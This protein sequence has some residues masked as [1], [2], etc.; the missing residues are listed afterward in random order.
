[1][2]RYGANQ[3][4][5]EGDRVVHRF[6]KSAEYPAGRFHGHCTEILLAKL[7]PIPTLASLVANSPRRFGVGW[8]LESY[9]FSVATTHCGGDPRR[10]PATARAPCSHLEATM[11]ARGRRGR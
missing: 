9:G 8:K 7:M 5:R 10:G 6:E 4:R 3:Y 1:M 2:I 11:L